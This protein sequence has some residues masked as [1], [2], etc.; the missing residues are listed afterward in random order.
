M[1]LGRAAQ[2]CRAVE[3]VAGA[4]IAASPRRPSPTKD[5]PSAPPSS[6]PAAA[7]AA[8]AKRT[9]DGIDRGTLGISL[10]AGL[11]AVGAAAGIVSRTRRARVAV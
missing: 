7:P 11:L 1:A 10:A 9:D 5:R 6:R 8:A 4:A 2:P 3:V